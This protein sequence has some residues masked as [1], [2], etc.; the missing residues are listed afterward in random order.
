MPLRRESVLVLGLVTATCA[1][2]SVVFG[3]ATG[4]FLE[5][6]LPKPTSTAA[7]PTATSVAP[8][9]TPT[10]LVALAPAAQPG[11]QRSLLLIGVDDLG[12]S[13]PR[14]EGCWVITYLV[15][16]PQY[17][18]IGF[19][20]TAQFSLSS[21]SS[22]RSLADIFS[23]DRRQQRGYQFMHDAIQ[24]RL[25]GFTIQADLILDRADLLDLIQNVGGLTTPTQ[26]VSGIDVLEHYDSLRVDDSA[27]RMTYQSEV[28]A[29]IFAA[30]S[31]QN[32][33]PAR[34]WDYVQQLPQVQ[35]DTAAQGG[36]S[37]FIADAPPF[38]SPGLV[39]RAFEPGLEIVSQP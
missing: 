21:L 32:W 25:P 38:T 29:L 30:L 2:A 23:E 31:R 36:L 35:A 28:F 15:G 14:M 18:V 1:L 33:T 6:D 20:P 9:P 39:W 3:V 22:S 13:D 5:P 17:Y 7:P 12:Q 8:T 4:S 16:M 11:E 27:S 19:L 26:T 10:A 34:V 37:E 24:S